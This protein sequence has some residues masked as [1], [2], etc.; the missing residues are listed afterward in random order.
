MP[1]FVEA[2]RS[3]SRLRLGIEGPAGSGKTFTALKIATVLA[4]HDGGE[5]GVIDSERGRASVYSGGRPYRFKALNLESHDPR[6]YIEAMAAAR[7][8]GFAVVVVDSGSHEWRGTLALVDREG[9]NRKGNTW[10]AWSVARPLHDQFLDAVLTM[11]AHVIV[12]Y[13]AKQATEQVKRDGVTTVNKL[14]LQAVAGD[15]TDYEFDLWASVDHAR[16]TL[17]VTKSVIDTIPVHAEYPLGDGIAESYLEWIGGGEY[18]A[19]PISEPEAAEAIKAALAGSGATGRD[20]QRALGGLS[21]AQ[22]MRE[23][24]GD[25]PA[26]VAL[27]FE[28]RDARIGGER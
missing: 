21:P 27:V 3:L 12:T 4:E 13:R 23:H 6:A 9:G 1:E 10:S 11:P 19:P 24:G 15:D 26:L 16:H 28:A 25:L 14:G 8:A 18:A 17:I 2:T 5:I 22:W 20:V 7:A